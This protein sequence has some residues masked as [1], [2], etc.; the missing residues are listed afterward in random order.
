MQ[1]TCHF[2]GEVHTVLSSCVSE[3][4]LLAVSVYQQCELMWLGAP[5]RNEYN[6]F[7]PEKLAPEAS[8]RL[9]LLVRVLLQ[10]IHAGTSSLHDH[11][12][13]HRHRTD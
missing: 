8:A 1:H 6:M 13:K 10:G 11:S 5:C 3:A 7:Y 9:L 12:Q 2:L 4:L